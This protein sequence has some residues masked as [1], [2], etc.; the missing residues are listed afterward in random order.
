LANHG[1]IGPRGCHDRTKTWEEISRALQ[2][3]YA[4]VNRTRM[5]AIAGLIADDHIVAKIGQVLAHVGTA[6]LGCPASRS[7][8]GACLLRKE[9]R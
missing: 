1:K 4:S 2:S 7:E 8:A 3:I 6:A 9:K 5:V